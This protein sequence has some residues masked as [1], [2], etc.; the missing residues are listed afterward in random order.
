MFRV[1]NSLSGLANRRSN[2]PILTGAAQI[3]QINHCLHIKGL[4]KDLSKEEIYDFMKDYGT[5]QELAMYVEAPKADQSQE[6]IKMKRRFHITHNREPGQTAI[7]RYHEVQ[8]AVMCKNELH[9]RP[10]PHSN[11]CLTDDI[12][13]MYPRDRPLINILYETEHLF[14]RLR[15]WVRRDLYDSRI[16]IADIEGK[17]VEKGEDKGLQISR[18]QDMK[19]RQ[20][21]HK[22][23]KR[24]PK[25]D[26]E[27]IKQR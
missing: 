2:L 24:S 9:W 27:Q 1:L 23:N 7:V 3:R 12:I 21:G 15:P 19:N 25:W 8:S 20:H 14:L 10:F 18:K 5:I 16:W 6:N 17:P 13:K 22:R 4:P 26:Q 11:Y